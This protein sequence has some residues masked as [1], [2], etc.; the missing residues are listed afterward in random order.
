MIKKIILM[1]IFIVLLTGCTAEYNLN[2]NKDFIIDEDII[3]RDSIFSVKKQNLD[4][5]SFV[6]L[7]VD[8]YKS[9]PRYS[10]YMYERVVDNSYA[11]VIAKTTYLDFL[12]Y[13]QNNIVKASLFDT[14][15]I[16]NNGNM[17][18]FAYKLKPRD[19][20]KIF[21]EED[22]Y[23]S[24]IDEVKINITLPFEVTSNN[25]DKV[26][27]DTGT[28]TWKYSKNGVLKDIN[29]EFNAN[30]MSLGR[31]AIGLYFVLGFAIILLA[32]FGYAFYKYK[33]HNRV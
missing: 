14:F 26:N 13:K 28:Y 1:F 27:L 7:N 12:S 30:K 9:D 18:I 5:D 8:G 21:E 3:I 4:V 31:I 32:I 17:Y 16:I 25:A 10:M 11:K 23:G 15:N 6:E 20:I 19:E 2:I 24:L 33:S 29:L 22:L